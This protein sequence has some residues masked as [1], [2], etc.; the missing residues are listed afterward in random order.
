M[1]QFDLDESAPPCILNEIILMIELSVIAALP[2][3]GLRVGQQR[4]NYFSVFFSFSFN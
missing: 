1:I 2:V 4:G 3:W